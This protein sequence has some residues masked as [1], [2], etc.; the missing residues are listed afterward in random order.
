MRSVPALRAAI[1]A[2]KGAP[3]YILLPPPTRTVPLSPFLE[4]AWR[5]TTRFSQAWKIPLLFL[6][7]SNIAVNAAYP[8][9]V[10]AKLSFW[11]HFFRY[12]KLCELKHELVHS[13]LNWIIPIVKI[14]CSNQI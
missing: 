1:D 3:W 14:R 8:I 10:I 9:K 2:S 5:G 7:I 13:R 4:D 12:L 6:A 11:L